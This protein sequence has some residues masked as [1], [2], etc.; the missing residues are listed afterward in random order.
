MAQALTEAETA[1]YARA[2]QEVYDLD[3]MT[4]AVAGDPLTANPGRLPRRPPGSGPKRATLPPEAWTR[5]DER[6]WL[7]PGGR[8]YREETPV[9]QR[10]IARRMELGLAT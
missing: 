8:R 6:T 3:A 10:V 1:A 9:V 4:M 5:L 2:R 7:S